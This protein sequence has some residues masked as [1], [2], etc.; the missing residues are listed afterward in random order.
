MAIKISRGK[1]AR[2]KEGGGGTNEPINKQPRH[3]AP[4]TCLNELQTKI[5]NLKEQ[6]Q[7]YG[8]HTSR[9]IFN[10]QARR[11][12][13][14]LRIQRVSAAIKIKLARI[15]PAVF[16]SVVLRAGGYWPVPR[17]LLCPACRQYTNDKLASLV[18]RRVFYAVIYIFFE[19]A[20]STTGFYK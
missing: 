2:K 14:A 17:R 19:V 18:K 6:Q 9:W 16:Y 12:A 3:V 13:A 15:E 8:R 7:S 20:S 1:N 5:K 4:V 10:K 11:P